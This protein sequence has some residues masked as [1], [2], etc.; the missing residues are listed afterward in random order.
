MEQAKAILICGKLCCGKSTY[1]ETLR[2]E[3]HAA[4]L[5]CDD[6]TL[7]LFDE[8]LGDDHERVTQ[9][10]QDYLF[11]RA[12]ELLELGVPVILEWGF[13]TRES[14]HKATCFFREQGFE[15]EWHYIDISE[16][17][18]HRNIQKRNKTSGAYFV[19]EGLA[20]KCEE[21]FEVPKPEEID[22]WYCNNWN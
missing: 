7:A 22:I 12:K 16:E 13:W 8:Q 4:V 18:W 2:R 19:D 5:S 21:L 1:T 11:Q 6:L 14:R 9:K 3:K 10:A 15:T 17:V 20:K